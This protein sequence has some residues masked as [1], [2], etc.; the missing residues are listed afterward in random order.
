M[1]NSE[2]TRIEIDRSTE[3]Y[4]RIVVGPLEGGYGTTLG[5]SLIHI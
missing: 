1:Q 3:N 5:L 2:Q 4:G